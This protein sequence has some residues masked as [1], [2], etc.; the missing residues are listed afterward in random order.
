MD[1]FNS[2]IYLPLDKIPKTYFNIK[3]YMKNIPPLLLPNGQPADFDTMCM[4]FPKGCVM[5]GGTPEENIPIEKGIREAYVLSNRP[6]PLARAFRLEHALGLDS[7]KVKI[8]YKCENV[9]PVGSHK[10]NT[11]IPQAYYA[12]EDKLKGLTTETGAGQWG[13]AIAFAGSLFG[14]DI[15]IYQVRISYQQKP[16]RATF[17]ESL[18]GTLLA[19]PSNTGPVKFI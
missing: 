12:R 6:T 19:S 15:K 2:K 7:E 17:M 4:M 10:A 8:F 3:A 16:G 1:I 18:G 5:H 11:A 14:L 9:S 13:S